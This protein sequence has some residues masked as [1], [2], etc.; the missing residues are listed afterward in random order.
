[1]FPLFRFILLVSCLCVAAPVVSAERD[2]SLGKAVVKV[3]PVKSEDDG[4]WKWF[5][6][7]IEKRVSQRYLVNETRLKLSLLAKEIKSRRSEW[8]KLLLEDLR[9]T[10]PDL[11]GS[12]W[13]DFFTSGGQSALPQIAAI[14]TDLQAQRQNLRQE[15]NSFHSAQQQLIDEALKATLELHTLASTRFNKSQETYPELKGEVD[16]LDEEHRLLILEL[17]DAA[18]WYAPHQLT[19]LIKQFQA[20][21]GSL[22]EH[23]KWLHVR[24]LIGEAE[25]LEEKVFMQRNAPNY[26][27]PKAARYQAEANIAY[28]RDLLSVTTLGRSEQAQGVV[29][30]QT[31]PGDPIQVVARSARFDAMT[32]LREMHQQMPDKQD[33]F[34][35]LLQQEFFF[36]QRIADKID[37]EQRASMTAFYGY[38]KAR[39]FGQKDLK[40]DPN[41][42]FDSLLFEQLWAG[43]GMGPIA[44][45]SA[46]SANDTFGGMP[47]PGWLFPDDW[48]VN[49]VDA[50]SQIVGDAQLQSAQNRVAINALLRMMKN[51]LTLTELPTLT[52]AKMANFLVAKDGSGRRL[53]QD[54]LHG[55]LRDIK[56]M[57]A[58]LPELGALVSGDLLRFSQAFGRGHYPSI[59]PEY[60]WYEWFG[61]LFNAKNIIF[62]WGPGSIY[63]LNDKV[64]IG[65]PMSAGTLRE[66]ARTG[67]A[68]SAREKFVETVGLAKIANWVVN[69][70][71]GKTLLA[72]RGPAALLNADKYLKASRIGAVYSLTSSLAGGGAN[73]VN[74]LLLYGGASVLAQQYQYGPGAQ[75]L[76]EVIAEIGVTD[77]LADA[78]RASGLSPARIAAAADEISERATRQ[79]NAIDARNTIMDQVEEAATHPPKTKAAAK[80]VREAQENAAEHFPG[81][82]SGIFPRDLSESSEYASAHATKALEKGDAG[83]TT[84]AAGAAKTVNKQLK[85]QAEKLDKQAEKA[86]NLAKQVDSETPPVSTI[87][88]E[89]LH[90]QFVP[91]VDQRMADSSAYERFWAPTLHKEKVAG[92]NL[93]A[94]D[95]AVRNGSV[96]TAL[97][98]YTEARRKLIEA[99]ENTPA[100]AQ[101]KEMLELL[102]QRIAMIIEHN[103][104]N[105]A[106]K[107]ANEFAGD[108]NHAKPIS[109]SQA[110]EIANQI[111]SRLPDD[112]G[113]QLKSI[114]DDLD[115]TRKIAKER[116]QNSADQAEKT[117]IILAANKRIAELQA[118]KSSLLKV[119]GVEFFREGPGSVMWKVEKDGETF[120]VKYTLQPPEKHAL[121]LDATASLLAQELGINT[122]SNKLNHGQRNTLL[123]SRGVDIGADFGNLNDGEILSFLDEFAEQRAFRAWLGDPDGHVGNMMVSKDGQLL[124][125]DFDRAHIGDEKAHTLYIGQY[126]PNEEELMRG[127]VLWSHGSV[128]EEIMDQA[129]EQQVGK[130]LRLVRDTD[131]KHYSAMA[132]IEQ[133]VGYKRLKKTV[134]K[135]QSLTNDSRK[136][137]KLLEQGGWPDIDT[138]AKVLRERASKLEETLKPLFDKELI[139]GVP[140]IVTSQVDRSLR[141]NMTVVDG[142]MWYA[143]NRICL[144]GAA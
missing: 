120:F 97:D 137:E 126:Y 83:A 30:D 79:L 114:N 62:L 113:S 64:L 130:S 101:Q 49:S 75:F 110:N 45:L 66:A 4:Y 23:L 89:E 43:L 93:K 140:R 119:E 111:D 20:R 92:P 58:Q 52:P 12:F 31:D 99:T 35:A 54:R 14:R 65:G 129:F 59:Y 10:Q 46:I 143:P 6:Q 122:F 109:S 60:T 18:E 42:T 24:A 3:Q 139:E 55:L 5:V 112:L 131:A 69:G 142:K 141:T 108:L 81:D 67:V 50:M 138:A 78:M 125:F 26:E 106:R 77:L 132:R 39:G 9:F 133:M 105:W 71:V 68:I 22:P 80:S 128:G 41:I 47:I 44:A 73:I 38:L 72:Q 1:M 53:P 84:R 11:T 56:E 135:I 107:A 85:E 37:A 127:S 87:S 17:Y 74:S 104:T 115:A 90:N 32:I 121:E 13:E 102:D 86:K 70:P 134:D 118:K 123:V 61:D 8:F 96:D 29:T 33:I 98:H 76:I 28:W 124:P 19:K 103:E 94:G 16:R 88:R 63:S 57:M 51:G 82:Q 15:I 116:L 117:Q 40:D 7:Y 34:Q 27:D 100:T 36:V 91:T 95:L 2:T 136:L 21:E 144:C 48:L 25:W